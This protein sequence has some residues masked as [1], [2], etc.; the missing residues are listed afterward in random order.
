MLRRLLALLAVAAFAPAVFA[1][2]EKP[3]E[4]KA[5][6]KKPDRAKLFAQLDADGD[7]KLTKDEFKKVLDKVKE[8]AKTGGAVDKLGDKVL[9]RVFDKMDADKDGSVSQ[10]EFEKAQLDAGVLKNLR[11]QSGKKKE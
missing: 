5:N 1:E 2:D 11:D 7:G 3:A 4:K 8:R 9:D 10:E 6:A